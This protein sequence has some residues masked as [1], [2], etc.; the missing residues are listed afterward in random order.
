MVLL[1]YTARKRKKDAVD[2]FFYGRSLT[3]NVLAPRTALV[4]IRVVEEKEKFHAD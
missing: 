2:D 3:D 4:R 1:A